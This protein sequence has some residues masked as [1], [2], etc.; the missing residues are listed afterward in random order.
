[1]KNEAYWHVEEV[2]V[3]EEELGNKWAYFVQEQ[4]IQL[5]T[6]YLHMNNTFISF[7]SIPHTSLGTFSIVMLRSR[8]LQRKANLWRLNV[9]SALR[10]SPAKHAAWFP[11]NM[12][13]LSSQVMWRELGLMLMST[14]PSMVW[15]ETQ[16]SD[17]WS[18]SLGTCL[19]GA[20][21]TASCWR[22]WTWVISWE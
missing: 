13:L 18:R 1:M 6:I 17:H 19:R 10:V 7:V 4:Y 5:L 22:C 9:L 12:R 11:S 8:S 2:V 21:L 20:V 3:T 14:L 16:G 15:T